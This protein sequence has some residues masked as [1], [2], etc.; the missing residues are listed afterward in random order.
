[1]TEPQPVDAART[2][3]E[4]ERRQQE[5]RL[6]R[7]REEPA[8]V[9]TTKPWK[10]SSLIA[11]CFTQRHGRMVLA[12]R[13]AKRPGGRFRGLIS[14]FCPLVVN[15][16]G[17]GD[18]RNLTVARW[19]GSLMPAESSALFSAFYVNEL[20]LRF[21]VREEPQS[22]L[23]DSYTRTLTALCRGDAVQR[24]LR[25]FEVDLLRAAGWGQ[26]ADSDEVLEDCVL[27]EGRLECLSRTTLRP[28][29]VTVPAAVARAILTRDFSNEAVLP[30][31]RNVLRSVIGYYVGSKG[32][33]VRRTMAGWQRF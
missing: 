7:V 19:L 32:L 29:D 30:S 24:P 12:V 18:V 22:A 23:F 31:A 10:E 9:L 28:G 6:L 14:P 8:F 26:R 11:E 4:W 25:E 16:S 20:L 3:H 15:Y 27:R 2:L 5:P 33:A 13:G 1:M 17:S 21:T